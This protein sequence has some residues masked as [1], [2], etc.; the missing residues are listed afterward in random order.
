MEERPL[1][2]LVL[3][4][5]VNSEWGKTMRLVE[6]AGDEETPLQ[7]KLGDLAGA[8]GKCGMGVAVACFIA[9]LIK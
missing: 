4:V 8:I 2:V 1:T 7:E 5:G 6:G 3:A 9:L